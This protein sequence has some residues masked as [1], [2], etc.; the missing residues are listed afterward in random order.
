MEAVRSCSVPEEP[1]LPAWCHRST[2][3]QPAVHWP[4]PSLSLYFCLPLSRSPSLPEALAVPMSPSYA[5][6]LSCYQRCMSVWQPLCLL[7]CL[8]LWMSVS[9]S[10]LPPVVLSA[11]FRVCVSV[12][13]HGCLPVHLPVCL[14]ATLS[15]QYHSGGKRQGCQ[16]LCQSAWLS[17]CL[18]VI[19]LCLNLSA[20]ASIC[21]YT[22]L[23]VL[24]SV[25]YFFL[26]F[27]PHFHENDKHEPLTYSKV[28]AAH[29]NF[30][31]TAMKGKRI[32]IW[33]LLDP[34]TPATSLTLI[35]KWKWT[36]HWWHMFIYDCEATLF[37]T[38][39]FSVC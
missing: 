15:S 14:P 5:N 22:Y 25:I 30:R 32:G 34:S 8:L 23:C 28:G 11:F 38:S 17:A 33:T 39:F 31:F 37:I 6:R 12:C 13:V 24:L 19:C 18:F 4:H 7:F 27:L 36:K 16:P 26:F 21:L 20:C 1:L 29:F 2:V 10:I 3:S 35:K 9:L